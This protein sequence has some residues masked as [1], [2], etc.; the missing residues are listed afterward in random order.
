VCLGSTAARSLLDRDFRITIQR[1]QVVST[2]LAPNAL[3]TIH[4]SAVLRQP[5]SAAR[6]HEQ[7]L[8]TADL[9][10]AAEL[11]SRE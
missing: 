4:P 9:R 6:R 11:L 2:P 3:A 7:E 1:G 5:T 8:L 10:V